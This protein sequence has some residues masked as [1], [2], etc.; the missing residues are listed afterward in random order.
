MIGGIASNAAQKVMPHVFDHENRETSECH[1]MSGLSS[2]GMVCQT[3][4]SSTTFSSL[5]K[6]KIWHYARFAKQL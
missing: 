6:F 3:S 5:R 4:S 2:D 1:W